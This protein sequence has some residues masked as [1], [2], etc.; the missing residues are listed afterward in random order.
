[1][2]PAKSGAFFLH[3]AP[4]LLEKIPTLNSALNEICSCVN[5]TGS[6]DLC[7]VF[8]DSPTVY[9]YRPSGAEMYSPCFTT[10]WS[11]VCDFFP[12]RRNRT[13]VEVDLLKYV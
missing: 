4:K 12:F 13:M 8:T 7:R 10:I 6:S 1:M 11:S 3:D 2:S 9:R 5:K